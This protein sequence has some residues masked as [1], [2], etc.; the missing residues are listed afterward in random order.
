MEKKFLLNGKRYL[1]FPICNA[2]EVLPYKE[3]KEYCY[4]DIIVDGNRRNT[5][6]IKLATAEDK[7]DFYAPY[8]FFEEAESVILRCEEEIEGLF[9]CVKVGDSVLEEPKLY[10]P[11]ENEKYRQ[12]FHFSP[13]IGWINDPN[14][15]FYKDG[16]FHLYF[17]HNPFGIFH[18]EVNVSWGHAVSTDGIHWTEKHDAIYPIYTEC[19]V[20]SGTSFVDVNNLAGYGEGIIF[21]AHTE[22]RATKFRENMDNYTKGQYVCITKDGGDTFVALTEEPNIPVPRGEDWR[23]P[24]LFEADG[25]LCLAVYERKDERNC[26]SFYSSNNIVDWKLESRIMDMYECPDIFQLRAKETGTVKWVLYSGDG[27]YRIGKFE[28]Y[29]FTEEDGGGYLD[30]GCCYAGQTFANYPSIDVRYHM[31]W[32]NSDEWCNNGRFYYTGKKFSQCLSMLCK[33][34][35]HE[36]PDG[37]FYIS[38][39]PKTEYEVLRGEKVLRK[40]LR[41]RGKEMIP[42]SNNKEI[43]L[44]LKGSKTAIV[45]FGLAQLKFDFQ[46]GIVTTPKGDVFV[47][48]EATMD[49]FI[50]Q[51]TVEIFVNNRISVTYTFDTKIADIVIEGDGVEAEMDVYEMQS[52]WRK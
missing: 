20:A 14:G 18:G 37:K 48:N 30:Y 25:K 4:V 43:T 39:T 26:I 44:S 21:S 28:K 6:Y 13:R 1:H 46:S 22:L 36:T 50:D 3:D 17:Q 12:K 51:T 9:D 34:E 38:R 11:F 32:V 42:M 8:Y 2:N 5:F 41:V 15:L 45:N 47:G 49:V 40:T 7:V 31:A 27:K 33:L 52:A 24:K 23:D 35:L 29:I 16:V 19:L 10:P